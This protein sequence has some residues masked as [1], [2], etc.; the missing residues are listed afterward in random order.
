MSD[1][2]PHWLK[3]LHTRLHAHPVTGAA[4]K[5]VVTAIGVLVLVAGL[6]MMVAP[7]PGIVGII[8]GLAILA[9]EWEFARRWLATAK[10]T[11]Q[12][13]AEKARTMD[14]AVRRKRLALTALAV[15]LVCAVATVLVW[16]LGWPQLAVSGW[17][18][19]Q[20]INDAVPELPGM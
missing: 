3:R 4:T 6:V 15:A 8:A 16:Q 14:P 13:A 11:A 18:R 7:G 5:V 10:R 17:D 19:V 2:G 9:T 1:T 12:D 20:S